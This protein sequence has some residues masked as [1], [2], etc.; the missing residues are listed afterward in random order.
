[1]SESRKLNIYIIHSKDLAIRENSIRN[2]STK[3]KT[4]KYKNIKVEDIY[5]IA[6][7]DPREIQIQT[8]Q[9]IIDYS[10]VDEPHLAMFNQFLKNLHINQLSN[11][12]KHV[13]ALHKITETPN[14]DLHLVLE[15]DMLFADDVCQTLDDIVAKYD[16]Q[17]IVFLGLPTNTTSRDI[18]IQPTAEN[19]QI[20]PIVDSFLINYETAKIIKENFFPIRYSTIVQ[21]NYLLKKLNIAAYQT[22][23]NIFVNGSKYGMFVSS[24]NPNNALIFNKD[25]VTVLEILNKEVISDADKH[26]IEKLRKESPI[27][28]SPDFLYLIARY[29]TK[30]ARYKEAEETYKEA[31]A[32]LLANNGI[33]NHESALLKDYIRLFKNLQTS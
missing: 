23:R 20:V 11:T 2:L 30:E 21:F 15:D 32:V 10:T 26:I 1:M 31:Y 27:N 4:G 9:Q 24:L 13:D 5:V 25:Y 28:K 8:I 6:S 7:N 3:L 14:K 16:N 18:D 19:F 17:P 22:T 12:L 33:L 29:L